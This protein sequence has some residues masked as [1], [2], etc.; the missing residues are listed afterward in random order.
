MRFLVALALIVVGGLVI[1][2]PIV[3]EAYSRAAN[4]ENVA[5]FY[6]RN[7]SG[8]GLP[9]AMQPAGTGPYAWACWVSGTGIVV[10]GVFAARSRSAA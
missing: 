9:E 1:V 10:A 4:R 7:S 8:I 6:R 5:E 3:A 2:S